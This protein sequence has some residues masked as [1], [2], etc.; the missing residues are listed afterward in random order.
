[1]PTP[2]RLSSYPMCYWDIA[3]SLRDA[4]ELDPG[5]GEFRAKSPY[6]KGAS[7]L[8]N[9]CAFRK[10]LRESHDLAHVKLAQVLNG[11]GISADG[12]ELVFK[13]KGRQDIDAR[14]PLSRI[15]EIQALRLCMTGAASV[16]QAQEYKPSQ[17][18]DRLFQQAEENTEGKEAMRK[19]GFGS[20]LG[21]E[22]EEQQEQD[23][24]VPGSGQYPQRERKSETQEGEE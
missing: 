1:M 24:G 12:A 16:E 4:I 2:K 18:F 10:L 11:Y 19:L 14:L 20:L 5:L 7:A 9:I 21:E 8:P 6:P 17:S 15:A 13:R 3:L 22:P 23:Q